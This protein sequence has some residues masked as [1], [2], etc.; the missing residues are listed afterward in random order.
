M[1]ISQVLR[2]IVI[3]MVIIII[4]LL[5][6]AILGLLSFLAKVALPV[7]VGLLVVAIVLRFIGMLRGRR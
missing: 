1:D 4:A 3:A 7:L 5:L 6:D 2:W